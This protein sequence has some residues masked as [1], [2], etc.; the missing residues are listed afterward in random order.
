MFLQDTFDLW[1]MLACFARVFSSV[2]MQRR[3]HDNQ[4]D[5]DGLLIER[6]NVRKTIKAS[7]IYHPRLQFFGRVFL[8]DLRWS[9]K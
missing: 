8:R 3:Y 9:K 7:N 1:W 2:V 6:D 4:N 5:V